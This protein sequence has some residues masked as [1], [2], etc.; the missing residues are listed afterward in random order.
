MSEGGR[1]GEMR[2]NFEEVDVVGSGC[3]IPTKGSSGGICLTA[4]V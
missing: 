2:E 3:E 1:G 4:D